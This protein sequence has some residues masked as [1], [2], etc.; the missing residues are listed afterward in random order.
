MSAPMGLN[1]PF[2][3]FSWALKGDGRNRAMRAYQIVVGTD[4]EAVLSGRG[5]LWDSG[6]IV[7]PISQLVRYEGKSLPPHLQADW[8]VRVWDEAG[9]VGPFASPARFDTGLL[10]A[11]DWTAPWISRPDFDPRVGRMAPTAT[12]YD[13]PFQARPADYFRRAFALGRPVRRGRLY[14]TALGVYEAHL[15]GLR[16]GDQVLAPGWTDYYKRVEYQFYDVTEHLRPGKNV[17][18]L[19]AGEG[20]YSGRIGNTLKRQGA[21]YGP[22]A[23]LT[24]RLLVEFEDGATEVI[25]TDGSWVTNA[26]PIVYSDML[27]GEKCDSRLERPGWASPGH[28]ALDWWPVEITAPHPRAPQL[29]APRCEPVRRTAELA[30]RYLHRSRSGGAIF[31]LGQNIAGWVRLEVQ[32]DDG[33]TYI[34]RHAEALQQDGELYTDNLRSASATDIFIAAQTGQAAYEPSFTFHGFRYVEV[35]GPGCEDASVTGIQV[36][37]DLREVGTFSCG[38]ERLDRLYA[39]IMWSQRGN[40]LS[41]PTDC[42]QR[43][44]RLGWLADAQIFWPTASFNM[45]I[46]AFFTKWMRDILD[47]QF[48]DGAFTDVAPSKPH[49]A[50]RPFPAKGAPAWGDGA[51]IMAWH[52]Y[53]FY[54]DLE[55][56][57]ASWPG[58]LRWMDYIARHNPDFIRECH[59]NNNYGDWLN[60]GAPTPKA[61]VATAYWAYLATLMARL[62]NALEESEDERHFVTLFESIRQAFAARFIAED[63]SLDGDTQ[64]GYLLAIDFGLVEGERARAIG[65]HLRR[66]FREAND[67]L[68]TGFLGVRHVC[69]VLSELG[70]QDL[71][72]TL[73]LNE[74]YPSWLFPVL[75]GA[76]TIWERWDG[77]TP[78]RGF[79]TPNMNSLNHYAYGAIGEWLFRRVAG[80]D[81]DP[82]APGFA[83]VLFRPLPDRRLGWA[84][85]TYRSC[86]GP[87]SA[88]W[89]VV[90]GRTIYRIALPP[91]TGGRVQLNVQM[92]GD[93]R[94]DGRPIFEHE[95]ISCA[96]IK[97]GIAE[98]HIGSG[99]WV[100]E[101]PA[102]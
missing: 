17:L 52:H 11:G 42:P 7:S 53:C 6:K 59:T 55:L 70:E 19:V 45:D 72:Y 66:A 75:N 89:E 77:W 100:F 32:A 98:V 74:T 92:L 86:R 60:L 13:N 80:I 20:W 51:V 18:G 54:G 21:H 41:V 90:G 102:R 50:H 62:A 93:L 81:G 99:E 44:E 34:L 38:N 85:A 4:T 46:A 2:P 95:D 96:E 22:K 30:G 73:L 61:L 36:N 16:L 65:A 29:D 5:D 35:S 71:A 24:A 12:P 87:V 68:A 101:W 26:G 48:E 37:S 79:Q 14:A 40:F 8:T 88:G 64:T 57:R 82:E 94:L 10:G 76:T 69:P 58:L 23:A 78:D 43:D 67:H 31:D 63:G 91:N 84:R 27:I 97:D 49:W 9:N 56:V 28:D 3:R 39:N 33:A 25:E 83:R 15:N 1:D 47:A